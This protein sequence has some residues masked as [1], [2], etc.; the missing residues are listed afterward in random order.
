MAVTAVPS[1]SPLQNLSTRE[2]ETELL[3]L[4]GHVAAAQCR[5][6]Q[7]LAEYDDRSARAGPGLRS[8]AHWLSW[9]I[10]MSLRT[11]SEHVRVA[12][13][14]AQLPAVTAAF[15]AGKISYS[16]VRAITRLINP[17]TRK[18][19]EE[20]TTDP[21]DPD[22]SGQPDDDQPPTD[23]T[24]APPVAPSVE[25]GATLA[26]D[27]ERTLLNIAMNG[28]ASHVESVVRATRRR[29]TDALR[30]AALRGVS[31]SWAEDGS[32]QRRRRPP[33]SRRQPRP[34][35]PA[36]RGD[37]PGILRVRPGRGA[38]QGHPAPQPQRAALGRPRPDPG[39]GRRATPPGLS[40]DGL[41][42]AAHGRGPHNAARTG[43]REP[44]RRRPARPW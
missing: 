24:S 39:L 25:S 44:T 7:R 11:A 42:L 3:T 17:K 16:K 28:T 43:G 5:V 29:Q 13:A 38:R 23:A 26:A 35:H 2:L 37:R 8:C 22:D 21:D 34:G 6:L 1:S 4:A 30:P 40:A 36:G 27:A 10:G 32:L 12:H 15:A 20:P 18:Q 41:P 19:T 33:P 14:L 9:R 31:W